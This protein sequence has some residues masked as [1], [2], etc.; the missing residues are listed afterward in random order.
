[1]ARLT[2]QRLKFDPADERQGL[3][4]IPLTAGRTRRPKS[5]GARLGGV[6]L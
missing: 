3:F 4:L 2:G 1:M 5:P 6:E